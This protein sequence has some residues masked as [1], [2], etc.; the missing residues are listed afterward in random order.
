MENNLP[1]HLA[2]EMEQMGVLPMALPY[3]V[4]DEPR[5]PRNLAYDMPDLDAYGEPP[6]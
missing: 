1:R 2:W 3:D 6:F 4:P 5:V